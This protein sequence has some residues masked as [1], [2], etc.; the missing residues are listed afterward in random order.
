MATEHNSDFSRSAGRTSARLSFCLAAAIL[1]MVAIPANSRPVRFTSENGLVMVPVLLDN[2]V[3]ARFGI[4]TGA[5][6]LYINRQFMED[7][8]LPLPD[9]PARHQVHGIDGSSAA[10]VTTLKYVELCDQ[11]LT[12]QRA[13]VIDMGNMSRTK[14][15]IPDGLIGHEV[16]RQFYVT[17]DYPN[18]ELSIEKYRPRILNGRQ[19]REL[20][21]KLQNHLILIEATV[22]DSI[23]VRM[24]LDYGATVTS[25]SPELAAR[26]GLPSGIDAVSYLPSL[27][28]DAES[29]RSR[30]AAVVVDYDNYRQNFPGVSFDGIIGGSYLQSFKITVDYERL[31]LYIHE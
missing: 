14:E 23:T 9:Q 8:R 28:I 24:I 27:A 10:G 26:L 18:S 19:Y 22:A 7:N 5:D 16:L 29:R 12:D 3:E 31:L 15:G 25:V 17:I 6:E 30:V 4:D 20:R 21:F 13:T 2:R 1:I 11:R